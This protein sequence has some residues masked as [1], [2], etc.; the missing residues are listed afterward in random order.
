MDGEAG[1]IGS[2]QT[3]NGDI[4]GIL[5]TINV[6]VENILNILSQINTNSIAA[7]EAA[8]RNDHSLDDGSGGGGDGEDEQSGFEIGQ[9]ISD[10]IGADL[11]QNIAMNGGEIAAGRW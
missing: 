9:E 2:Q 11:A 7:A 6:N 4:I 10:N 8:S 1:I 5:S 3:A